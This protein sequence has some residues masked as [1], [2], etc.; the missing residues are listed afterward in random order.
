[1][2][3]SCTILLVLKLLPAGRSLK[4]IGMFMNVL[5]NDRTSENGGQSGFLIGFSFFINTYYGNTT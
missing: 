3:L 1:M 4:V 5:S 2:E